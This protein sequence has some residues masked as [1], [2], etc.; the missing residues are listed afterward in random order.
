MP[1]TTPYILISKL[2]LLK[3]Q[4]E[5]KP[6]AFYKQLLHNNGTHRLMPEDP[7]AATVCMIE[8]LDSTK[9]EQLI[10]QS[11]NLK[12]KTIDHGN[13]VELRLK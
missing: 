10:K 7:T 6:I 1:Q 2:L 5:F 11:N 3:E 13:F 8:L 4:T 12:L 9:K